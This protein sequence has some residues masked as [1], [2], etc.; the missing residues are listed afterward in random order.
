M[1]L[2]HFFKKIKKP[3]PADQDVNDW[4][5]HF[6][7]GMRFRSRVV[8]VTKLDKDKNPVTS[9]YIDIPTCRPILQSDKHPEAVAATT[10]SQTAP[11]ASDLANAKLI[12]HG[13]TNRTD[14]LQRL[15]DAKV[16]DTIIT[17][18]V[19]ASSAGQITY[20]I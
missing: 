1:I 17:A 13:C 2:Y 18:F 4:T 6:I 16:S 8:V 7:T 11:E 10:P 15:T 19:K 12:V 3:L 9:Y 5:E 20:P 14:A